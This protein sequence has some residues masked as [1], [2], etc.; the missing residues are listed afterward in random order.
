MAEYVN[1]LVNSL[2][3]SSKLPYIPHFTEK[4]SSYTTALLGGLAVGS[5]TRLLKNLFDLVRR[6]PTEAPVKLKRRRGQTTEIPVPVSEEE[7]AYLAEH[8]MGVKMAADG[9]PTTYRV[10]RGSPS[11]WGAAGLGALAA[12]STLGGWQA[13]DWLINKLRRRAMESDIDDVRGRIEKLLTDN[14]DEEDEHL[15]GVMKAA[16]DQHLQLSPSQVKEAA[17]YIDTLTW[18][19]PGLLGAAGV[20]SL[21]AGARSADNEDPGLLRAREIAKYYNDRPLGNQPA[22]LSPVLLRKYLNKKKKEQA[23]ASEVPSLVAKLR[24]KKK[25]KKDEVSGPITE[26]ELAA[27]TGSPAMQATTSNW[28]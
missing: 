24:K 7:A 4:P 3:P 21:M 8:G 25:S 19:L 27:Q 15:Y 16:E 14:P 22:V 2:I 17:G 20:T 11:P 6:G 13:T 18:V 1:S 26:E 28:F 12:G 5:T 23:A 10:L 9:E